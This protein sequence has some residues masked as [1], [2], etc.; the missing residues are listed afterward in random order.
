MAKP[1][2]SLKQEVRFSFLRNY[3][4]TNRLFLSAI[5]LKPFV[6]TLVYFT[7][8]SVYP[9]NLVVQLFIHLPF[10]YHSFIYQ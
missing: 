1:C 7:A 6:V 3:K 5:P 2:V 8:Y 9:I 10:I 4:S